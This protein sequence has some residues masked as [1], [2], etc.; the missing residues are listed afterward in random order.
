[1][2]RTGNNCYFTLIYLYF[3]IFVYYLCTVN[4]DTHHVLTLIKNNITHHEL[5]EQERKR[6]TSRHTRQGI[7]RTLLRNLRS[8]RVKNLR[9][10]ALEIALATGAPPYHVG[11]DRACIVVSHLLRHDTSFSLK[12]TVNQ[13][14]WLEL[15]GKVECLMQQGKM[16]MSRAITL[17]L[18]Q[19]RASRFYL[20][21]DHAWAI[22][23]RM[24]KLMHIRR[25]YGRVA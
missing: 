25:P 24:L 23:K 8:R 20:T 2:R 1:M 11:Y 4:Y 10:V 13:E 9:R 16:S 22:I 17:V 3:T 21:H 6:S 18:E 15:T 7:D 12:S 5:F 19:C 14:M